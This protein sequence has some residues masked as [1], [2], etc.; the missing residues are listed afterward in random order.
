VTE[1]KPRRKPSRPCM[2]SKRISW[3]QHVQSTRGVLLAEHDRISATGKRVALPR[4]LI[5]AARSLTEGPRRMPRP[6]AALEE[7][8]QLARGG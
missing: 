4:S 6:R 1:M 3:E 7:L 5:G 2:V 8:M